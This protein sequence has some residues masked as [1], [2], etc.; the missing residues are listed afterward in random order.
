MFCFCRI[1]GANEY[2]GVMVK[3]PQSELFMAAQ[4]RGMGGAVVE[5]TPHVVEVQ[6]TKTKRASTN[7]RKCYHSINDGAIADLDQR[8]LWIFTAASQVFW[9]STIYRDQF[10]EKK[11]L[12]QVYIKDKFSCKFTAPSVKT[13]DINSPSAKLLS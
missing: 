2:E 5:R 10:Y 9:S 7:C 13:L 8:F 6:G 4:D 11:D 3:S 1:L 12:M